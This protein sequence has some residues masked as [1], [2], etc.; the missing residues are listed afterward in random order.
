MLEGN[1]GAAALLLA[2]ATT[3]DDSALRDAAGARRLAIHAIYHT[4][5]S[6][7]LGSGFK[8]VR[9]LVDRMYG[10]A[11]KA[12]E[13]RFALAYLRWILL[14]DGRGGLQLADMTPD[15][16]Q[17]L[18]AQ[19]EILTRDHPDFD[20]P[21]DFDRDRLVAER[22][23]VRALLANPPEQRPDPGR[24]VAAGVTATTAP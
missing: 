15:V 7:G 9:Q 4:V 23:A 24:P 22:D 6:R 3:L 19:L 2:S 10:V 1:G 8:Q 21:G 20:G 18:L 16:A 5:H 11:A 12:P 14:S 17:D 13:T